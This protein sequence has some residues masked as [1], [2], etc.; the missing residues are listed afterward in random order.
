MYVLYLEFNLKKKKTS[1]ELQQVL[2]HLTTLLV[3]IVFLNVNTLD[4]RL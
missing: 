1:L 2:I 3:L 4:K